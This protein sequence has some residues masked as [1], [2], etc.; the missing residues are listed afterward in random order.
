MINFCISNGFYLIRDFIHC[1]LGELVLFRQF[2]APVKC[3][4][5]NPFINNTNQFIKGQVVFADPEL[6]VF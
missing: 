4:L 5:R 6:I 3:L 1:Y 2:H